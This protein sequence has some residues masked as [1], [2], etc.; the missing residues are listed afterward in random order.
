VGPARRR[1]VCGLLP[2]IVLAGACE[3]TDDHLFD[4]IGVTRLLPVDPSLF[5][6]GLEPEDAAVQVVEWN[7]E[8]AV[9]D[10]D[11]VLVGLIGGEPCVF[12]DTAASTPLAV[13]SAACRS[14][15]VIGASSVESQDPPLLESQTI[16]LLVTVSEMRVRRA[17]PVDLDATD[18]YD[19]DGVPNDADASGSAF[20]APCGLPGQTVGCD[21]NCPLL[22]N[23]DQADGNADGVGDACSVTDFAGT[24]SRDSDGDGDADSADNCVWIGNPD[25]ADSSSPRDGIGDACPEQVAEVVVAGSPAFSLALGPTGLVQPIGVTSFVTVDFN[26]LR[27]LACDWEGG[28]CA[29]DPDQVRLC[30]YTS[31]FFATL[32]CIAP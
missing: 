4:E 13:G 11:S 27:A 10:I 23:P 19:G 29:L 20:D 15:I 28:T 8:S 26:S 7:V 2:L 21:D 1:L 30:G 3:E 32:G 22:A 12:T 17:R 18:D 9:L 25:Q 6:A 16:T 14:G 24:T 31:L 5:R